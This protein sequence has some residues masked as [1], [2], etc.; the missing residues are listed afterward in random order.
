MV[1][2]V[3]VLRLLHDYALL[4]PAWLRLDPLISHCFAPNMHTRIVETIIQMPY[5]P[6]TKSDQVD[7]DQ[8]REREKGIHIHTATATQNNSV[9]FSFLRITY[10]AYTISF[11]ASVQFICKTAILFVRIGCC[12]V[13]PFA[14]AGSLIRRRY[15]GGIVFMGLRMLFAFAATFARLLSTPSAFARC[16]LRFRRHYLCACVFRFI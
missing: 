2:A 5:Q 13:P 15:F 8:E 3:L 10:F 4:P 1:C 16:R 14:C 11:Y 9:K 6:G 7:G 12:V